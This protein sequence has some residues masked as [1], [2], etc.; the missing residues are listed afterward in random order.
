MG[1]KHPCN[2]NVQNELLGLLKIVIC[3]KC[4]VLSLN[5]IFKEALIGWKL[6]RPS[7]SS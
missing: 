1:G 7:C 4:H 3:P 6:H 2:I 5:Y